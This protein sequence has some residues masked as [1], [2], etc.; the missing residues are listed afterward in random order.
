M[1]ELNNFR[2]FLNE[3]LDEGVMDKLKKFGKKVK[4]VADK[5]DGGDDHGGIFHNVPG[6]KP[7]PRNRKEEVKKEQEG[8]IH[9]GTWSL[10][11]AQNMEA[12]ITQIQGMMREDDPAAL[13]QAFEDLDGI[14]YRVFGD[15][16]FHDYFGSAKAYV[17]EGDIDRAKNALG[18]ALGV[19]QKLLAYRVKQNAENLEENDSVLDEIIGEEK[20]E[21][22]EAP[23]IF[24]EIDDMLSRTAIHMR[25]DDFVD[26][27]IQEFEVI[28]GGTKILHQAL[29]NIVA[30]NNIPQADFERD[31]AIINKRN[32]K[33]E[34]R[35]AYNEVKDEE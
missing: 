21:V 12:A 4:D 14:M 7:T 32:K 18:D 17:E 29:K 19:A 2:N 30:A 27:L 1:K 22:N 23:K 5:M 6:G 13:M 3:D 35:S 25:A 8:E 15:D 11:S 24:D 16:G 33:N 34:I 31:Q 26:E 9:E 10:G 20:E 28:S